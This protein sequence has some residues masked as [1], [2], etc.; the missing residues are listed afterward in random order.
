HPEDG[1]SRD[2]SWR[3]TG[4]RR[5]EGWQMG[6]SG[7]RHECGLHQNGKAPVSSPGFEVQLLG[8]AGQHVESGELRLQPLPVRRDRGQSCVP[9]THR[10]ERVP[11]DIPKCGV[12]A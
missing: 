5:I 1:R 9:L 8:G 7:Q 12:A 10:S 3:R 4:H 11:Q 2:G 6:R